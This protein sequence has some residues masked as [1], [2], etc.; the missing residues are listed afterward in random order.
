MIKIIKDGQKEF[1]AKCS[2]CGCEFSYRLIDVKFSS[3]VCPCCGG[4]V[5][6]KEFKELS[7]DT[8]EIPCKEF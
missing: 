2:T 8:R 3:V 6:H 5:A 7:T 4:Y 1:I